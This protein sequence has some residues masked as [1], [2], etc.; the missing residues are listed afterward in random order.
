MGESLV[1]RF[2]GATASDRLVL[3]VEGWW[4]ELPGQ[5]DRDA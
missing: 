3:Y 2:T 4:E 1:A 5:E